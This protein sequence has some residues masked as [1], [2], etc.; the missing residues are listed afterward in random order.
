MKKLFKKIKKIITIITNFDNKFQITKNS[1]SL[2]FYILLSLVSVF[3]IVFQI[4]QTTNVFSSFFFSNLFE[5]FEENF[6]N[7]LYNILPTFSLSGFSI[8]LLLNTFYSA[9]KTINGYNRIADYVYYEVKKRVGI[10]YRLSAFLMFLM[11]LITFLFETSILIFGKYLF[12]NV[13]KLNYYLLKTI[14][15]IFEFSIIYLTINLL[16]IYVPPRRM[17]FK[18][19]YKG[20]L[21]ATIS[22][23]LLFTIFITVI[24]LIN[25]FSIGL[26]ILTFL[27][28]SLIVLFLINCIIIMG[29]IINYYGTINIFKFLKRIN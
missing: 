29:I 11:L 2:S 12:E 23:Y 27:S 10:K 26:S 3:L 21:F 16:L 22:I 20:A 13:L 25:K 4:M 15:L 24:N 14:Q 1:A 7:E 6:V 8:F 9:S 19:T 18:N 5:I 28:Y 17:S